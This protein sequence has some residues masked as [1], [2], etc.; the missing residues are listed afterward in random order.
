[1]L[2]GIYAVYF[3]EECQI[4]SFDC[5][6]ILSLFGFGGLCF[7]VFFFA[8]MHY[9]LKKSQ[10][11]DLSDFKPAGGTL[12]DTDLSTI[13]TLGSWIES[14]LELVC[15]YY[16]QVLMTNFVNVTVIRVTYQITF[17]G[18]VFPFH[19]FVLLV[20]FTLTVRCWIFYQ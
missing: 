14:Q 3:Q 18:R 12:D 9:S 13:D 1:M 19:H 5:M 15:A 10:D 8:I 20:V 2:P 11:G 6:L 4:A 7:A 17:L 16:G